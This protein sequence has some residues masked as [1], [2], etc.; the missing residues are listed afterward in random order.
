MLRRQGRCRARVDRNHS[1]SGADGECRAPVAGEFLATW[2]LLQVFP[3]RRWPRG[4]SANAR[5]RLDS[6][7]LSARCR[8]T[9]CLGA[10]FAV[11]LPSVAAALITSVLVGLR[12][13][14]AGQPAISRAAT[15]GQGCGPASRRQRF[16]A[17]RLHGSDV[18][19]AADFA[20]RQAG[21]MASGHGLHHRPHRRHHNHSC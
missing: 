4:R 5:R 1:E 8:L 19:Q 21:C 9:S 17:S 13:N 14:S 12:K 16:R 18:F 20:V 15:I 10:P 7:K 6:S 11:S 2:G 3:H